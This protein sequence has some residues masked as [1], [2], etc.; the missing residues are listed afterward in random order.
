MVSCFITNISLIHE[1]FFLA[2]VTTIKSE[3][4]KGS[5]HMDPD[6]H[7]QL[8]LEQETALLEK[9]KIHQNNIVLYH[10]LVAAR[11]NLKRRNTFLLKQMYEHYKRK[12][13]CFCHR[14]ALILKSKLEH[15]VLSVNVKFFKNSLLLD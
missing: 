3:D 10:T 7:A 15:K 8:I 4:D 12:K 1:L 13:V 2:S 6:I 11:V 9:Q 5:V 14:L